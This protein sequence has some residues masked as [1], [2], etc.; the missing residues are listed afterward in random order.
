[1][2]QELW[3][4]ICNIVQKAVI[5]IIPKKSKCKKAKMVVWG[6]LTSSWE[7]KRNKRQR[8]KGNIYIH[9]NAEFQRI[10]KRDKKAFLSD[11][12]KKIEERNRMGKTRDLFKKT[13]DIKGILHTKMGAIKH[14]NCMDLT[15]EKI[16]KRG[17]K[18]TQT[19]YATKIFMTQITKVVWSLTRHPGMWSQVDLRKNHYEQSFRKWLNY[20]Y[21]KS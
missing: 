19:N 10:V 2:P 21:F 1:M 7:K 20:S 8:W 12:S 5:K 6:G 14:R 17:E 18:N 15:E 11:Q 3:M 16:L 9:L 13:R 4:E